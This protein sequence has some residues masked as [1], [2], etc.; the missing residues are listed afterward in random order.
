MAAKDHTVPQMYL[1]RF[2]ER[3]RKAGRGFYV[4]AARVGEL[5][6]PWVTNVSNVAALDGFYTQVDEEGEE[7]VD[8]ER[9]L[10]V[11][12]SQATPA[13]SALLDGSRWAF[14]HPWPGFATNHRESIAWFIAAQVL[15]TTR[16]RKRLAAL[17]GKSELALP[18][19][20][21]DQELGN[22]HA[23]YLISQ[24]ASLAFLINQRP[25]GIGMINACLLTTDTPVVILNDHDA[26]DQVGAASFWEILF[27]LDPHRLLFLP[28]VPM[29]GA[30][31]KKRVDHRFVLRAASDSR[32]TKRPTT[33]RIHLCLCIRTISHKCFPRRLDG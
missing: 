29:V 20:L 30:D 3:R 9:F 1:R 23:R 6:N 25:W 2:A 8:L 13:F 28:S 12:E 26:D 7:S 27:P 21:R 4:A 10:S 11:I 16:Q 32:S 17:H 31:P 18:S 33:L 19:V 14:P 22:E 15:R 5:S 24:I